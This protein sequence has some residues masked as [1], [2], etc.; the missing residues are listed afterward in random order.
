MDYRLFRCVLL[1]GSF[2]A[3]ACFPPLPCSAQEQQAAKPAVAKLDTKRGDEML[4]EYFRL[5][6]ERLQQACL[7]DVKTAADWKTREVELR[8]QLHEMLGL[9]PL[10]ERTDLKPVITGKVEHEEF[11]VEKLHFQ[12]RPGLYVTGNLYLPK[13]IDKPLPAVLY[14]CGHG[15]IKK[16]GIA[17]GSKSHYQ[18][19]G[20]WFARNGY[21]CLT[22]DTLQ[23][24]EIEGIH[25]GTHRYGM[26]WWLNRG[27]TP[28]G[29][30]AWNCI[31]ALDYLQSR[32]EVDGQKLG[33]T[34]RS[35]GGAYSW[36]ISA[37]DERIKCAVPTAGITDLQNY[38]VDGAVEGHCDCM[39]MVNTYQWDYPQVAAMVAPRA[40]LIAN[41]DRDRIFPLDGVYR[42]FQKVRP[43]YAQLGKENDVGLNITFGGHL[44]TQEL[45]V[46]AFRWLNKQLKGTDD[47]VTKV[48]E[49]FF[50]PEQLKVFDKLP[51]DQINTTIHETFVPA[52]VIPEPLK[53][54]AEWNTLRD[55]YL[56]FLRAKSFRAW[57][58]NSPPLDLKEIST[59]EHDGIRLTT[60]EFTSQ[61][62]IRLQLFTF[63]R[64][65]LKEPELQVL[66]VLDDQAWAEF[67][68]LLRAGFA[69]EFELAPAT[70][71]ESENWK[72]TAQ[73]LKK[74]P[75]VMSYCAPRGVGPTA[76]D[77]SEKKQIQN[78][79]RFYLLGQTLDG[80]QTLD[81]V[82]AM[83]AC[84]TPETL[85]KAAL[86]LQSQRK[87][88][89][90]AL[91]AS[92][93]E[94][95]AKRIDLYDLPTTHRDG[96][97]YLNVQ[98]K[99]DM[100]QAVALAAEKTQVVIYQDVAGF[101]WPQ[102]VASNLGWEK[103]QLQFRKPPT[104][105]EDK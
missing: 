100:P 3:A 16:D 18:H 11:T 71:E 43:L 101:E 97:I 62:G 45:Q 39:F 77:Q 12:S 41:T 4:A 86:W 22:I 81:I 28:A 88:G 27:Y 85:S 68:L 90:N 56:A 47:Q 17:Y 52:A 78:R 103:K 24:G 7:N 80:M 96:P 94:P 76:F 40:L 69:K 57:P 105:A 95:G 2:F 75:W 46:H 50:Q 6:T 55:D 99:L 29:V 72:S 54:A 19:H 104:P 25:H 15:Q 60:S 23:L 66:N 73:M 20:G 74:F 79:R 34:G 51:E 35:G 21:V 70:A 30:E 89:G 102:Q 1:A 65:D 64:A 93:M 42:T 5:E 98:R 14:V 49:K 87:M 32:K 67:Q 63:R 37:L 44:D 53:T 8:R 9:D 38:V 83:K 91:Y 61:E 59:V 31:R 13:T 58:E 84:R 92:I 33:V 36:W 48:T 82:A 26:W 10:P